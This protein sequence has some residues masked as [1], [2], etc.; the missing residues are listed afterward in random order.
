MKQ[1]IEALLMPSGLIVLLVAMAIALHLV[2]RQQRAARYAALAAVL[3]YA[4]FGSGGVANILMERLEHEYPPAQEAGDANRPVL[5]VVLA[6]YALSDPR[7]PITGQVNSAA[8]FRVM[9]AARI[10]AR[11]PDIRVIVSGYDEVPAIMGGLLAGLGVAHK[12]I[13]VDQLSANTYESAVNLRAQLDGKRFYLVTSAGHMPRALRV[14]RK[15][16]LQP[17]PAPTDYLS[18]GTLRAIS[19]LPSARH[20][21]ISDLAMHEYIG[22][23]WYRMLGRI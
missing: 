9:E 22:L 13:S 21:A 5:M 1:L 12:Q 10:H 6:G 17:L 23:A 18:S 2:F 15:Q 7:T 14:F 11:K 8:G 3:V 20:L 19:Y 4:V 16:G